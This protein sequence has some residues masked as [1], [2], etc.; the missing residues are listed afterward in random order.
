MA[1]S[2]VRLGHLYE[3]K[4]EKLK[5]FRLAKK[6]ALLTDVFERLEGV[7]SSMQ[8]RNSI[9]LTSSII[10]GCVHLK[11]LRITYPR[12]NKKQILFGAMCP[13]VYQKPT[14]KY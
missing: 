11:R 13:G 4:E 7:N 10:L 9:I 2:R 14:H 1:L 12:C 6:R 5:F 8:G 3:L